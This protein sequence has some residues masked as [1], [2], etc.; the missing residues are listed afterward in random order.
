[1]PSKQFDYKFIQLEKITE[2]D[3]KLSCSVLVSD[4][5]E[6]GKKGYELISV[7]TIDELQYG[8]FKKEI[9]VMNEK[10]Y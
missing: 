9:E 7:V 2:H 3:G 1:M 6:L 4:A 8:W 10:E 5:Q